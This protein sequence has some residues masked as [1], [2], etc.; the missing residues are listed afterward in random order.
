MSYLQERIYNTLGL[1]PEQN[2]I[3][4]KYSGRF[5]LDSE[6][7]M[8]IFSSDEHDNIRILVYDLDRR[9]I[10]YPAQQNKTLDHSDNERTMHYYLTRLNPSNIKD[11]QGKYLMPKGEGIYP[12]IP[13]TLLEKYERREEVPMLV[14]TEGYIKA[15]CASMHGFDIVGLS[16]ITHYAD[17]KTK[18]I[19]PAIRKII[20]VCK[21]QSVVILYDGDCLNISDKDLA[22]KQDVTRRPQTF[23]SAL[24]KTRELLMEFNTNI[25][26]AHI[27]SD[28]LENHPKG[29]DDL[30][31]EPAFKDSQASILQDLEALGSPGTY[32]YKVNLKLHHNR[33]QEY[34]NLKSPEGFYR[35]WQE[36][37][38]NQE[39]VYFGTTYRFD[40]Q[41]QVLVRTVPKE[42]QNFIR[43]GDDYYEKATLHVARTGTTELRLLPRKKGTII[44]D[45]GRSS[46][47]HIQKFKSF[48]N[49]PS[50]T[51]YQAIIDGCYN[52]YN[53]LNYQP[54]EG[55][56]EH[57]DYLM[58]HIFGEQ[59]ELGL[60]YMQLLY[61][62][63][64]Q[65]LP[66]LCLVSKERGTGKTSFLD[67]LREMYGNNAINIGNSEINSEFNG[68][69]AG[70]LVVGVDET[71]LD[72][73]TK[74]TE[75]I[76]MFATAKKISMQRKGKDYEE[77]ENFCKFVMCSNNETH[78]IYTQSAEVR[79]WVRKIPVLPD[80]DVIPDILQVFSD[81]IPAF[82]AFLNGR[83]LS[84]PEPKSRMW[85]SA[86]QLHTEALG[87]LKEAQ[88]PQAEREIRNFL[89]DLF[90]DF[91]K[92]SYP[93]SLGGLKMAIPAIAKL[94]DDYLHRLIR[95]NMEEA[96]IRDEDGL[97]ITKYV[98]I[99]YSDID[100]T[101]QGQP[102]VTR[103]H[104][105]RGKAYDFRA[106]KYLPANE[107]QVMMRKL[108][109][110]SADAP[111]EGAN[112]VQPQ[113]EELPF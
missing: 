97:A 24:T 101:S 103:Y 7:E 80:E 48:I 60:D 73:N 78:F 56:W 38:G 54:E 105:T 98:N 92:E 66:I 36:K 20:D 91:P 59:Y 15:M 41:K 52:T 34:F 77:V 5:G 13:P 26:F 35:A 33:L 82:L 102:A 47:Q 39:F 58:H 2:R 3:R 87:R 74:V 10:E 4:V 89:R 25:Y 18:H 63:P 83:T 72:D 79:F 90:N 51:N 11:G 19:H 53:P 65:I 14:L 61:Q 100:Y 50:H 43:V 21:V 64:M 104:K 95:E 76:K 46:L 57:I 84:V 71:S 27:L 31:L 40:A 67:L 22:L 94:A 113:Q 86:E 16:S 106:E 1:T 12:F 6:C 108:G 96:F 42:I 99:P 37:I 109:L 62:H 111:A 45:F 55:S 8:D 68:F 29:L 70:K 93:I 75:K 23:Y 28:S 81:E 44:D 30:L 107:Y 110:V 69:L 88:R 9:L 17:S 49:Y 112:A 32:F 85:F